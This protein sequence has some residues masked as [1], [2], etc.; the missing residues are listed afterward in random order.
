MIL[1][2]QA[3]CVHRDRHIR[4]LLTV[5]IAGVTVT[6]ATWGVSQSAVLVEDVYARKVF[7][8]LSRSL[9][10]V[11]GLAATSV[12]EILLSLV[13]LL[14]ALAGAYALYEIV[15]RRR[16]IMSTVA[17]GAHRALMLGSVAVA[18]FYLLWGINYARAPLLERQ[19]W[20]DHAR[21]PA[22]AEAQAAE[23]SGLCEDLVTA[24]NRS[25][26]EA[27]RRA[28]RI[29]RPCY[30]QCHARLFRFPARLGTPE[31][32][33]YASGKRTVAVLRS[34]PLGRSIL[35]RGVRPMTVRGS[36][37]LKPNPSEASSRLG[38]AVKA[39][40]RHYGPPAP[41]PTTAP[42][43]LVLWENV[44]YLAPPARRREAFE[45]LRSTIGTNPTAI[46]AATRRALERV[47]AHGILKSTFATKLTECARI[48]IGE[49]GGDIGPAT[50]GP[51]AA[52]KRALRSFPG[53]GEPGA[54]KILLFS[55]QQPL[56]AP[57]SNGLRVLVRLGV[58]QE[59]GSYARTYAAS[60]AVAEGLSTDPKVMQEAHLLLQQHG[61]TLCKCTLPRCEVCPLARICAYARGE[62]QQS[63]AGRSGANEARRRSS[64]TK[65]D[66][67][68]R[69][70]GAE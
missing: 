9:S 69:R 41:L 49:F 52:A 8:P 46:L 27:F 68:L 59:Q 2:E 57:E 11:S 54:E 47:T 44:A 7:P 63:H 17:W 36:R 65:Y 67:T 25:Y 38:E 13:T 28:D 45:L 40:R 70:K 33:L 62:K 22:G 5:T 56:L 18:S 3:G 19:G 64:R 30:T 35:V 10:S 37:K 12:A 58:V 6:A 39:L 48:A 53:I 61:R 14:L 21:A 42:F 34:N 43:E 26:M 60:R 20:Q 51:I 15:T 24:A 55:G 16:C 50:R 1:M 31:S 23:L 32:A 66:R 29:G 4:T